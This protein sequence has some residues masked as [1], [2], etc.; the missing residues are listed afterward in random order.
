MPIDTRIHETT[1]DPPPRAGRS[2]C[3]QHIS[4]SFGENRVLKDINLE[5]RSGR[6]HALIGEN[7]A[8]KSTLLKILG[9]TLLP[10]SGRIWLRTAT[11]DLA[12]KFGSVQSAQRLGVG[13]VHQEL[14]I[15]G[16]LTAEENLSFPTGL[17]SRR[18]MRAHF[19]KI[20]RDFEFRFG[21]DTLA[22]KLSVGDRQMLE[23]A[24]VASGNT[25]FLLLDEP[26]T[27]LTEIE[28]RRL[29]EVLRTLKRGGRSVV[30][31]S[32][33]MEELNEICDE[34][35]VLRD[36]AS[37]LEGPWKSGQR[38]AD[39][40]QIISAMVGREY[41]P[42]SSKDFSGVEPKSQNLPT[43]NSIF[44]IELPPGSNP[45]TLSIKSGECLG[46][47]GLMGS[48]RTE[49]LHRLFG[50]VSGE[51][52]WIKKDGQ[53]LSN[54][55]PHESIQN[56]IGLVPEERKLEGLWLEESIDYNLSL[57]RVAQTPAFRSVPKAAEQK[58]LFEE[59]KQ[60]LRIKA[61]TGSVPVGSLS[62]G[63]QQK[64]VIARALEATPQLLLI[65]EP[66]RGVDVAARE[67]LYRQI[68]LA[69][70]TGTAVILV[71]SDLNELLKLSHR[72]IV[73]VAGRVV[74]VLT[75]PKSDEVMAAAVGQAQGTKDS[76]EGST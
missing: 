67:D 32:H 73:L 26:T 9:G 25:Q 11:G 6:I 66:S 53:R 31:I 37:V 44:E 60:S 27:S 10:D 4:K 46:V 7:G 17:G 54:R 12:F 55:S 62:G 51:V 45:K 72:L 19:L 3:A 28:R 1:Q 24:R 14:S 42:P 13:M 64:V 50:A 58:A 49:L 39:F 56:G 68:L 57:P 52:L 36:G 33:R 20:C 22:S 74:K 35:T 23:V 34:F 41:D 70:K 59:W 29:F 18:D 48:G 76:L 21:P 63:N 8:G 30:L 61:T 16:D 38:A 5:L 71:S 40:T 69:T 43:S 65:D 15:I 2:L 75:A 47:A